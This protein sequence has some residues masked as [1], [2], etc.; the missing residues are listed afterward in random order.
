M[1]TQAASQF[2]Q[3]SYCSSRDETASK[4]SKTEDMGINERKGGSKPNAKPSKKPTIMK[5][6]EVQASEGASKSTPKISNGQSETCIAF[7]TKQVRNMDPAAVINEVTTQV[8]NSQ[9]QD[10][11]TAAASASKVGEDEDARSS[12]RSKQANH[13]ATRDDAPIQTKSKSAKKKET[14]SVP[15]KPTRV[16]EPAIFSDGRE[17]AGLRNFEFEECEDVNE[18]ESALSHHITQVYMIQCQ[19]NKVKGSARA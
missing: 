17:N 9:T 13:S 3:Q 7:S 8:G 18:L 5:S 15:N 12:F 19:L 2:L 6:K 4:Q 14:M 10:S 11:S 1:L 16:S